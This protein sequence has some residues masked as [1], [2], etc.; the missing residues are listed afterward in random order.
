MPIGE[1]VSIAVSGFVTIVTGIILFILKA[2]ISDLKQYRNEREKKEEAK[3][4]LIL[5]MA[6]VMLVENYNRCEEK[7]YYSMED[8]EVYGKLFEAYRIN[9]GNG[10]I[11]QLAPKLRSMPMKPVNKIKKEEE[12]TNGELE[13]VG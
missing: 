4:E 11:D 8:R 1:I 9:G 12:S 13:R 10:V 3:D 2:N 5:G 7:G 6:R